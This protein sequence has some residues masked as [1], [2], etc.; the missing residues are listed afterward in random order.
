MA[1]ATS[2]QTAP[3]V[4]ALL[5]STLPRF[6]P[7][8]STLP[9]LPSN[10]VSM[11]WHALP[12]TTRNASVWDGPSLH[13]F[14]TMQACTFQR[15][16]SMYQCSF[17]KLVPSAEFSSASSLIRPETMPCSVLS[18]LDS[19]IWPIN[20]PPVRTSNTRVDFVSSAVLKAISA[21]L[22]FA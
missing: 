21:S 7:V 19:L 15:L 14:A 18:V 22:F 11:P 13:A 16:C 8:P 2:Q 20:G 4:N 17:V 5:A 10:L 12:S 6:S 1:L 3:V 9:A